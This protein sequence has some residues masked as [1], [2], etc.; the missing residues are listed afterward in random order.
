M[1][2]IFDFFRKNEFFLF[3]NFPVLNNI[4]SD[5]VIDE[6]QYIQIHHIHIT[7]HLQDI[8]L[9][10]FIAS[11]V[12]YDCHCAIQLVQL[13]MAVYGQACSRLYMV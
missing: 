13:Q 3:N 4:N 7:F 12:F 8:L 1:D 9:S 11:G 6:C 2:D 10:H 5:I